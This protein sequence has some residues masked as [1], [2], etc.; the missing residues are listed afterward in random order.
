VNNKTSDARATQLRRVADAVQNSYDMVPDMV[1]KR[2]VVANL[3][4]GAANEIERLQSELQAVQAKASV[5]IT[6]E[7]VGRAEEAIVESERYAPGMST[8]ALARRALEAAF[9]HE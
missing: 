9:N 6:E 4:R 2:F 7:M 1:Q 8:F 3:M 5:E